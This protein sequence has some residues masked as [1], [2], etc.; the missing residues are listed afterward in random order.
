MIIF[1]IPAYNEEENIELLLRKTRNKMEKEGVEYKVFVINDGSTDRTKE[2][3]ESMQKEMPIEIC[4]HYPNRGVGEVFRRGFDAALN[5]AKED[6]IIV[7]IEADNTSDLQI[8]NKLIGQL[9]NGFQVSLA[10]CYVK[11]G[12]IEGANF[13]RLTMSRIANLILKIF[14]PIDVNTYSSFYRAYRAGAL[15]NL[16]KK[17]NGRLLEE[18]GF[19]CMVSFLV[20]LNRLGQL[21]I[22]EVPM[23]LKGDRRKGKSK[24]KI[25]RTILGFLRV[26]YKQGILYRLKAN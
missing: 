4:S 19:E 14:F 2:I 24:M 21:R 11:G 20:K 8:L 5:I 17:H 3:A 7:T 16:F 15:K 18:D 25:F 6:D 1:I 13:I 10:S 26:I 23:V 12:R 9:D 22:G